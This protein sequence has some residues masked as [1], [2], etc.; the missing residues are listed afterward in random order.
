LAWSLTTIS[1]ASGGVVTLPLRGSPQIKSRIVRNSVTLPLRG[2]PQSVTTPLLPL[3][4]WSN[5]PDIRIHFR[6]TS[7]KV[8][9]LT[10]RSLRCGWKADDVTRTNMNDIRILFRFTSTKVQILTLY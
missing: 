6:F 5:V 7:T 4:T 1:P 8:Q 2:S 10:L 9:I 3:P